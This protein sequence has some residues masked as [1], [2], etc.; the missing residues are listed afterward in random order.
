MHLKPNS[1]AYIEN[2]W[3]W[4]ADHDLDRT[5]LAQ[6]DVYAGRGML[7]QSKLA[8]LWG[9]ASEHAVMYQYQLSAASNI[10]MGMIQTES[11]YFQ[12]TPRAPEPFQT[13][14]FPNDPTFQDCEKSP[15]SCRVSW[16]VRIIDTTSVYVLGAG[17][18]SWFQSY[19]QNCL[20]TEDCQTRAFEVEEAYDVWIYNLCTKAIVEMISPKNGPPTLAKDN[21]NGFLS[22]ILGWLQGAKE[23]TGRRKFEGFTVY[24]AE[25]VDG[26]RAPDTCKNA[27]KEL[28]LCSEFASSFQTLSYRGSLRNDTLTDM[29]C[30]TECRDSVDRWIKNVDRACSDLSIAEGPASV[31]AQFVKS[32]LDETCL[33]D[34]NSGRY[35]NGKCAATLPTLWSEGQ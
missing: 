32:G 28:V 12:P 3:A 9:T 14:L 11:P 19:S 2:M 34:K 17:I 1:T 27:L 15:E 21:I 7:I 10:L 16:A 24:D 30:D 23:V 20:K 4:V 8:Y 35:C 33:K 29:V 18:Y 6:I 22:S 26:L 13:G 5:D 31:P 25:F